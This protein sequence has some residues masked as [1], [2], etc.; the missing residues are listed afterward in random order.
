MPPCPRFYKYLQPTTTFSY[1]HFNPSFQL[2]CKKKTFL[3]TENN[4]FTMPCLIRLSR[5]FEKSFS[6]LSNFLFFKFS[7]KEGRKG[8]RGWRAGGG[9]NDNATRVTR[10]PSVWGCH[11]DERGTSSIVPAQMSAMFHPVDANPGACRGPTPGD[12]RSSPSPRQMILLPEISPFRRYD[13]EFR[14]LSRKTRHKAPGTRKGTARN[15]SLGRDATISLGR[16]LVVRSGD[17]NLS[18]CCDL[19]RKEKETKRTKRN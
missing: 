9:K 17:S 2:S 6:V 8:A 15:D 12:P 13:Q 10:P 16:K 3:G 14:R 7:K 19:K 4:R 5:K 11:R 18:S 1:L